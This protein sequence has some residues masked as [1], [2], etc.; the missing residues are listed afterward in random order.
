[1]AARA[2][3]LLPAL[4]G[5]LETEDLKCGPA[6]AA[7]LAHLHA[8]FF[9]EDE[10]IACPP[11][12]QT[13]QL[14]LHVE[15][16][17]EISEWVKSGAR[18]S[19]PGLIWLRSP[20]IVEP[21]QL[22]ADGKTMT[23]AKGSCLFELVPKIPSNRSWWDSSSVQFLSG[24][25]LRVRGKYDGAR[26]QL[27]TVNLWDMRHPVLS[28]LAHPIAEKRHTFV[29]DSIWPTE[30]ALPVGPL[31]NAEHVSPAHYPF[32]LA[33]E[34]HRIRMHVRSATLGVEPGGKVENSFFL[35][36]QSPLIVSYR[37]CRLSF[38]PLVCFT[39]HRL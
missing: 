21:V 14:N 38:L 33:A 24:R 8:K 36:V 11:K 29:C 30:W 6:S 20:Y 9:F 31:T 37:H 27:Q 28:E 2:P 19:K 12:E 35:Q 18:N 23:W 7:D 22:S 10:R 3:P 1:M 39:H 17:Q 16:F 25:P 15:P 13:A 34:S 26:P 32:L 4:R 5:G